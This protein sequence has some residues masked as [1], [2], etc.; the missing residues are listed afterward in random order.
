MQKLAIIFPGQGSQSPGMLKSLI[1][2]YPS[3][4]KRFEEASDI[5][6]RDLLAI[7]Q[8]DEHQHLLNST[9]ITQ[10]VLLTAGI[11]CYE[12]FQQECGLTP[13]Y[14]AG[15]SLGEYTA[16][17]ASGAM[18]FATAVDLVHERGKL[19]QAAVAH[20]EG[21]M[22]AI[23]GLEDEQV[24]A[25][26]ERVGAGVSA[27]NFNSPGQVV[28]AGKTEKVEAAIAVAKEMGAKRAVLLPVSVPSHC[29]LMR[30]AAAQLGVFLDKVKWQEPKYPIVYNVDAKIRADSAGI[31]AN[32]GA[33][34]YRPVQWTSCIQTLVKAGVTHF[35][36]A[37]PN[38]VLTGLNK[39]IDKNAVTV[40]FDSPEAINE[41]NT[42]WK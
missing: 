40:A 27:A 25:V 29:D 37:G 33:Q 22:A 21:A 11:A 16:L 1:E 41:I 13:D 3:M 31:V 8:S 30:G 32:L 14:M 2:A 19:M 35:V 9:E 6:H 38:K 18:D 4:K 39:R 36:E 28:I 20:G 5:I 23:L 34:L 24:V 26:C 15:H 42:N 17:C 7:S 10:P 12:V